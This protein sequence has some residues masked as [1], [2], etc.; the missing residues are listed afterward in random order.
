M[1]LSDGSHSVLAICDSA[2]GDGQ[3]NRCSASSGFPS[4]TS[5]QRQSLR[6]SPYLRQTESSDL[7]VQVWGIQGSWLSVRHRVYIQF[8]LLVPLGVGPTHEA[9]ASGKSRDP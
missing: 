2:L 7:Q 5:L 3:D 8:S 1:K 9:G 6:A 4:R